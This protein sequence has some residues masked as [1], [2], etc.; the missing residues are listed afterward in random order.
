MSAARMVR[1]S[2]ATYST[3]RGQ[4]FRSAPFEVIAAT[5]GAGVAATNRAI[6]GID[7]ESNSAFPGPVAFFIRMTTTRAELSLIELISWVR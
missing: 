4:I 6:L 3:S 7:R 1:R 5:N 2:S